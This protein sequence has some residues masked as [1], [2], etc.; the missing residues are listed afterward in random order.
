ME[1]NGER[2]VGSQRNRGIFGFIGALIILAGGQA[3]YNGALGHRYTE[4]EH[5]FTKNDQPR[6]VM[7]EDTIFGRDVWYVTDGK[8]MKKGNQ[9]LKLEPNLIKRYNGTIRSDEGDLIS[10]DDHT[11]NGFPM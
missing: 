7:R 8:G 11:L 3:V 4:V 5:V 6:A 1:T 2:T 9:Y 10:L